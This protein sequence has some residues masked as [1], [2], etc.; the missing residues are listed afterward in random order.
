MAILG[1]VGRAL[2]P[3][4]YFHTQHAQL[5]GETQI[6]VFLLPESLWVFEPDPSLAVTTRDACPFWRSWFPSR[7]KQEK[8]YLHQNI[9]K[10]LKMWKKGLEPDLTVLNIAHRVRVKS[11]CQKDW[12]INNLCKEKVLLWWPGCSE[13]AGAV[14]RVPP[15]PRRIPTGAPPA[16][17]TC[18]HTQPC[19]PSNPAGAVFLCLQKKGEQLPG[20]ASAHNFSCL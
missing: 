6:C 16:S 13:G 18:S 9:K 15:F 17:H 1:R 3:R 5:L 4:Q 2:P 20:H 7:A 12:D 10:K 19:F 8:H 11:W 14:L